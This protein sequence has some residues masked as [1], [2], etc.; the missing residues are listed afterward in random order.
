MWREDLH[1]DVATVR[2]LVDAGPVG[3]Y[4]VGGVG[5]ALRSGRFYRNHADIDLAIFVDDLA[6]FA[7]H[8]ARHGYEWARPVAGLALTPWRRLDVARPVAM[9]PGELPTGAA[10]EVSAL[11]LVRRRTARLQRVRRRPD[12]MDVM[13]LESRADGVAMLGEGVVVP[14]PDFL[15][16][17]ALGHRLLLPNPRY[18]AHLPARW[19]RQRRDL[20]TAALIGVLPDRVAP[21]GGGDPRTSRGAAVQAPSLS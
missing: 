9:A 16:A 8:A 11:R 18:K 14:W 2:S 21:G 20:R 7:E 5:L 19:P 6:A 15:P 12:F 13:L 4:L 17:T 3:V 10:P 1:D